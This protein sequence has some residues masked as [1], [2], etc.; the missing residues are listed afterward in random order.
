[1]TIHNDVLEAIRTEVKAAIGK[2]PPGPA[3]PKGDPGPAGPK[4][5]PGPAGPKGD[6]GPAG[7]KG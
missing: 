5:D 4:G 2:L 7:P 6:P 1:V 3:G